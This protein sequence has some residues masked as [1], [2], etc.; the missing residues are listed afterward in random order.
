MKFKI[1]WGIGIA[2][3][4]VA[5]V[6]IRLVIIVISEKNSVDLVS[7]DYYEREIRYELQMRALSNTQSLP[8]TVK[9]SLA[10]KNV[11]IVF[12]GYF[13]NR[14]VDG[15]VFF[16]RP[17]D[18]KQD[19]KIPLNLNDSL[20]QVIPVNDLMSGYWKIQIDWKTDTVRYYKELPLFL[21]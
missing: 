12:P 13:K 16:F 6:L 11:K 19:K 10:D 8:E 4:Y 21:Q 14:R 18:T 7:G 15:T 9:F 20:L 1:S 2:V 17:S 5:F 3:I